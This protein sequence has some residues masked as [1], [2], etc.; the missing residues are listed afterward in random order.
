MPSGPNSIGFAPRATSGSSSSNHVPAIVGGTIGGVAL[1]A[2]IVFAAIYFIYRHNK[3]HRITSATHEGTDDIEKPVANGTIRP[4]DLHT[5]TAEQF[6]TMNHPAAESRTMSPTSSI[7]ITAGL[8]TAALHGP[9]DDHHMSLEVAPPSYEASEGIR[10]PTSPT[11]LSP[12]SEKSIQHVSSSSS[13][14][15]QQSYAPSPMSPIPESSHFG[16]GSNTIYE[17]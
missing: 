1:L 7:G 8:A 11:P 13:L 14:G 4:F 12:R 16:S 2:I 3:S 17:E 5:P 6:P 15:T 9:E 10:S